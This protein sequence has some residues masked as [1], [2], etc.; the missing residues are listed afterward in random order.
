MISLPAAAALVPLK[1]GA[2]AGHGQVPRILSGSLG[3]ASTAALSLAFAYSSIMTTT[4]SSFKKANV[5]LVLS[6]STTV[7]L[8][9]FK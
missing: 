4:S 7:V 6:S 8:A 5:D 3:S 1:I 9:T 2:C